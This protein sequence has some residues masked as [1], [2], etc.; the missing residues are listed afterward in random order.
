MKN[1][2]LFLSLIVLALSLPAVATSAPD[3]NGAWVLNEANGAAAKLQSQLSIEQEGNKIL[4]KSSLSPIQR[5]YVVDGTERQRT[6]ASGALII[7]TAKW[8]G[9]ALVIDENLEGKTPFGG[10]KIIMHQVWSM[11]SNRQTLTVSSSSISSRGT[12]NSRQTY[13][14]AVSP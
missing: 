14:K 8:D 7:Y 9:E 3:F 12:D 10:T 2:L 4:I 5:E 11:D 6:D 13:S 1:A